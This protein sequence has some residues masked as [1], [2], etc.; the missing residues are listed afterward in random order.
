MKIIQAGSG[1]VH[2][3][4]DPGNPGDPPLSSCGKEIQAWDYGD[5]D[6]H[7]GRDGVA[8][9]VTCG[10]CIRRLGPGDWMEES[11]AIAR[12]DYHG[13]GCG[14]DNCL[15]R[16]TIWMPRVTRDRLEWAIEELEPAMKRLSGEMSIMTARSALPGIGPAMGDDL[17]MA[18]RVLALDPSVQMSS[19]R[20]AIRNHGR[21]K[22]I[23]DLRR[24][25]R[26]ELV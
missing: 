13:P 22:H 1:K 12:G 24:R 7:E 15:G 25:V 2:I 18:S 20:R 3:L 9:D 5:I 6:W 10:N 21:V 11:E 16:E 19:V 26:K 4:A 14:C 8:S 17:E 23:R